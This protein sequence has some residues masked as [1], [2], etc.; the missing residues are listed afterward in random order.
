MK[1]FFIYILFFLL[2][3]LFLLTGCRWFAGNPMFPTGKFEVSYK[4]L[5]EDGEEAT[6]G[7]LGV[8]SVTDITSD[9]TV[10]NVASASTANINTSTNEVGID[11]ANP[12]W[13]AV[14]IG[15]DGSVGVESTGSLTGGYGSISSTASTTGSQE[16]YVT[17][18]AVDFA[19]VVEFTF[20]PINNVGAEIQDCEVV[21]TDNKG[22]P[23]DSLRKNLSVFLYLP[24]FGKAEEDNE[25]TTNNFSRILNLEIFDQS[26][27]DYY[28]NHDI[29]FGQAI[30]TFNGIDGAGHPITIKKAVSINADMIDDSLQSEIDQIIQNQGQN[31]GSSCS[32]CSLK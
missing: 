6:N 10:L 25:E 22:I 19:R 17:T 3:G 26:T 29:P 21:Y 4:V 2:I 11:G 32:S 31:P 8:V 14:S 28:I 16:S 24:P 1:K 5:K 23:I 27:Q 9:S 13:Y 20:A 30:I 15:E 18:I 7:I 12:N